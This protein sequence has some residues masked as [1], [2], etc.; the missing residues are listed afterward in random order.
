MKRWL[1]IIFV[2]IALLMGETAYAQEWDLELETGGVWLSEND[3]GIPGDTGTKFNLLDLTGSGPEVYFRLY[4]TYQFNPKHRIRLTLAPLE[5]EGT[6]RLPKEV[7]FQNKTFL[8]HTDTKATYRFNTYRLTY[9][10][11]F[12]HGDSWNWGLGPTVL[13]RD[14]KI[15][16]EQGNQKEKKDDLGAVP[17]LHI[18]GSY[19]LSE[20]SL[21][22]FDLD[23]AGSTQGRAIDAALKLKYN[24]SSGWSGSVGYRTLEG[25]ADNESVYSFA[26]L[27]YLLVSA[28]YRF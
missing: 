19:K 13:I 2:V 16:L 4:G 17:L 27:H 21:I 1:K 15:Q 18:F 9:R 5:F 11:S 22:I 25:G 26:W 3:V 7:H 12:Y 20:H 6:G 23:G 8:A 14:A 10:W 28:S 24:L